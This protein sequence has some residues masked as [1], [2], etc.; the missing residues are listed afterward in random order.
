MKRLGALAA[1]AVIAA[2]GVQGAREV[3]S[4]ALPSMKD[5]SP[6]AWERL[7]ESRIYFGHQSVGDNILKGVAAILQGES[8]IRLAV[9]KGDT[10]AALDRP[11]LVQS[12]IGVN[13]EPDSKTKAFDSIVRSGVG[14]RADIAFFKFC[15][16]DI[17]ASTDV[18]AV[19][20]LY[21]QVHEALRRD[22]PATTFVHVTVPLSVHRDGI[23]QRLKA[24][25]GEVDAWDLDNAKRSELNDLI[26]REYEGKEPVFDVALAES[27]LPGGVR[28]TFAMGGKAVPCLAAEY[29]RDGAHLN[30]RGARWVAEQ[31]LITLARVAEGRGGR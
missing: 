21:K 26:V 8:G 29:S 24:L 14:G 11:A 17:R 27:T 20:R 25:L 7:A 4:V 15:F 18:A 30:D 6:A 3:K 22:Y 13:G 16:W 1:V 23:R 9:V 10:A 31:F 2:C 12:A 19:F 5:V 28:S